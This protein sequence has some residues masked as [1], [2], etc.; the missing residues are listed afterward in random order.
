VAKEVRGGRTFVAVRSLAGRER[1]DE[2]ARMLGGEEAAA[3][4]RDHAEA[5]LS[6]AQAG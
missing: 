5:M 2:I 6:E 1:V 3:A 4:A